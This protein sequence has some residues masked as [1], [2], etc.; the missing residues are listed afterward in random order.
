MPAPLLYEASQISELGERAR[1][2]WLL[3]IAPILL[4]A[5]RSAGHRAGMTSIACYAL[6]RRRATDLLVATLLSRALSGVSSLL[7]STSASPNTR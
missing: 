5:R 3:K 4:G 7:G 6:V 2:A 1:K